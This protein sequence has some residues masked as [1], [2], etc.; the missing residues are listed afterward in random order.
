MGTM[1]Y[2]DQDGRDFVTLALAGDLDF[3]VQAIAEELHGAYDTW[4]FGRLPDHEF[5]AVVE[6]HTKP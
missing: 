1:I 5:W 3:D 4:D 2:T 6:K